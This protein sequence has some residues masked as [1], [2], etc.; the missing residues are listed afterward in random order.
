MVF[1]DGLYQI[2]ATRNNRICE[3]QFE[4]AGKEAWIVGDIELEKLNIMVTE[5]AQNVLKHCH[6][7]HFQSPDV[8]DLELALHSSDLKK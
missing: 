8:A 3:L 2:V 1:I 7:H 5:V 4:R 6:Q